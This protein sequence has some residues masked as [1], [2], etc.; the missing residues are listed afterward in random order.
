MDS[1]NEKTSELYVLRHKDIDVALLRFDCFSGT[2][3]GVIEF[4]KKEELPIGVNPDFSDLRYWWQN[5][6]IPLTRRGIHQVL[7]NIGIQTTESLLLSSY[8]LSLTDHYWMCP[9]SNYDRKWSD[10]NFFTNH[11]SDDLGMLLTGEHDTL[12]ESKDISHLSPSAS[13]NGEMKKKWILKNNIPTLLKVN[14]NDSGQQCVNELI[15][16][17]LHE[18]LEFKNYVPYK[19]AKITFGDGSNAIGCYC[20]AFTSDKIEFV[21]AYQLIHSVK[22]PQESNEYEAMIKAALSAGC[23]SANVRY[24]LEYMIMTDFI[25]S[26]TDRHYNNFGFIRTSDSLLLSDIAP[27]YD[28]GNCLF[29]NKSIPLGEELYHI[30]ITSFANTET[31]QLQLVNKNH[32]LDLKKLDSFPDTVYKILINLCK[33]SDERSTSIANSV[34]TKIGILNDFYNGCKVWKKE[35]Y[36]W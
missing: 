32:V 18:L 14:R 1:K 34:K 5:R 31:K 11:F 30:P 2:L 23:N 8:G 28:T 22:I 17:K 7:E 21:S 24:Q 20:P 9:I 19:L 25:L 15:A 27:I 16:C 4:V 10:V 26:N 6:A 13:V 29:Y 12:N 3:I 36:R 33:L 35:K